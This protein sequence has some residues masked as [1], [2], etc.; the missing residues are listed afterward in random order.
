M[1]LLRHIA[2]V[3]LWCGTFALC[4]CGRELRQ[5]R[6]TAEATGNPAMHGVVDACADDP[7]K[8][9]AAVFLMENLD[10]HY[11][12]TFDLVDNSIGKISYLLLYCPGTELIFLPILVGRI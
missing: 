12:R 9:A 8:L 10:G 11:T 5:A 2:I 4:G 1:I 6:K 7:Q 3:L